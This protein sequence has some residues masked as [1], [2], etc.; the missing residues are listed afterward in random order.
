MRKRIYTKQEEVVPVYAYCLFCETQRCKVVAEYI[1]KKLNYKCV[2]PQIIQRKWIKGV[3]HEEKHD[4]LPGYI[5]L[6]SDERIIPR[7]NISGIIKC[8]GN[9]ELSGQD[10][11]FAEMIRQKD[12]IMGSISLIQEGDRCRI[13]DPAWKEMCGRVIKIDHERK[14]CCIEFVFDRIPRTLWIGYDSIK[15]AS[16]T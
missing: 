9:K 14:R 8:L 6:Y 11:A 7:F 2:Y 10:L 16:I 15:Q 4:W 12:G 1:S 3:I 5:F 13:D